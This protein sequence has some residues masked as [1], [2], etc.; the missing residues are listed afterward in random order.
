MTLNSYWDYIKSLVEKEAKEAT[1]KVQKYKNQ[2]ER[3][4]FNL[5]PETDTLTV[6]L[7]DNYPKHLEEI[8]NSIVNQNDLSNLIAN[9]LE[10]L[11]ENANTKSLLDYS[12]FDKFVK[13]IDE[14][15]KSLENT[16]QNQ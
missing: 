6:W 8:K 14:Q 9:S 4:D 10:K 11:S 1:E 7:K 16:E 12:F 15:I 13:K 3:L 5:F 2:Y